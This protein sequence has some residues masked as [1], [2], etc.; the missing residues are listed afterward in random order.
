MVGRSILDDI[1]E[2][3]N[4]ATVEGSEGGDVIGRV[5]MPVMA[6]EGVPVIESTA[7]APEEG[8]AESGSGTM[9]ETAVS[10]A[11]GAEPSVE[12]TT[13]SELGALTDTASLADIVE[14]GETIEEDRGSSTTEAGS[15][16]AGTTGAV[17]ATVS[18]TTTR[19]SVI[20]AT[21]HEAV[22]AV[23]VKI[24]QSQRKFGL[25]KIRDRQEVA[26]LKEA[27]AALGNA[28]GENIPQNDEALY[29]VQVQTILEDYGILINCCRNVQGYLDKKRFRSGQD[30]IMR[31]M[32][33]QLLAQSEKER[34][35]FQVL[36]ESYISGQ[37][38]AGSGTWTDALY[39]ARS[40]SLD[41]NNMTDIGGGT[42]TVYEQRNEDGTYRYIKKA[43]RIAPDNEMTTFMKMYAAEGALGTREI[44]ELFEAA[45]NDGKI[46]SSVIVN[47]EDLVSVYGTMRGK[48][49]EEQIANDIDKVIAIRPTTLRAFG[50]KTKLMSF[51]KYASKKSTEYTNGT[52]DGAKIAPGSI[53]SNRN[54][55]TSRAAK[56][57][58]LGNII[59]DSETVSL[60]QADGSVVLA[61]YME[62]VKGEGITEMA[63]L[64]IMAK[65][66][67]MELELTGNAVKEIFEL[68]IF[69]LICGEIDRHENNYMAFYT[70]TPKDQTGNGGKF[71]VSRIKGIDNDLSFGNMSAELMNGGIEHLIPLGMSFDIN[72]K[73]ILPEKISVPFISKQFYDRLMS[74]LTKDFLIME[75][76]DIRSK[77]ELSALGERFMSIQQQVS[78]LV[79][80]G[81]MLVIADESE[82]ERVYREK[83]EALGAA[84]NIGSSYVQRIF[85]A[86]GRR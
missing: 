73:A 71:T 51:L 60:I 11:P 19:R 18:G 10:G 67:G 8:V 29:A 56:R 44:E 49:T 68:Q 58:G 45:K 75:Q 34:D 82:Y 62:G 23:K 40:I 7:G 72:G 32:V 15:A 57:L 48:K 12:S 16:G 26:A 4:Q 37:L 54:V 74:P 33:G 39:Q 70:V 31:Q 77:T 76:M 41:V 30:T 1:T 6:G 47:L 81:K 43:D 2:Q 79:S 64:M 55:S 5:D 22:E 50:D 20:M 13:A 14:S 27:I 25:V 17:T 85:H 66:Q 61:N 42:S 46:L 80:S 63:K 78:A 28:L 86:L 21:D 83:M 9:G 59:A 3:V 53:V 24:L 52:E 36:R 69:D 65:E 35:V 38:G 84:G